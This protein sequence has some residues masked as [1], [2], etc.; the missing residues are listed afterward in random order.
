MFESY[1]IQK[2]LA[3][4]STPEEVYFSLKEKGFTHLLYDIN[5]VLGEMSTL[6]EQEKTLFIAFQDKCLELVRAEKKQYYLYRLL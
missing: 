1:T 2:I 6:S 5:Y 3:Q 4:S